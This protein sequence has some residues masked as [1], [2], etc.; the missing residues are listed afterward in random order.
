[1]A[2]IFRFFASTTRQ[3]SQNTLQ[4]FMLARCLNVT[5]NGTWDKVLPTSFVV[6][7]LTPGSVQFPLIPIL[8]KHYIFFGSYLLGVCLVQLKVDGQA[9]ARRYRVL[10]LGITESRDPY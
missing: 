9:P 10:V 7:T 4:E 3:I 8:A 5:L 2:E 6:F 1:M